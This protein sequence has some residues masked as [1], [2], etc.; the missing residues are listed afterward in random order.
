VRVLLLV[1]ELPEPRV[2]GA[3]PVAHVIG[4]LGQ[5]LRRLRIELVAL[6]HVGPGR[7]EEV[8]VASELELGAGL[9]PEPDRLRAA[10]A[11]PVELLAT[12]EHRAV[13]LV[14][15]IDVR[16]SR[17]NRP[18]E[19]PERRMRLLAKADADQGLDRPARVTRPGIAVVPVA[20]T[21]DPL[22]Q[23][24][25]RRGDDRTRAAADQ[26]L[27]RE[28]AAFDGVAPRAFV[29]VRTEPAAPGGGGP[30]EP[31]LEL[32]ARRAWAWPAV[33]VD[34]AEQCRPAAGD[35]EAAGVAGVPRERVPG[36]R[37]AVL[38]AR[39]APLHG[40]RSR[41]ALD[42]PDE[43]PPGE[44]ASVVQR[45]RVRHAHRPAG[46]AERG[47]ENVRVR[48]VVTLGSKRLVR[49]EDERA[50]GVRVEERG[51][52][53]VGIVTGKAQPVDRAVEGDERDRLSVADRSVI[54]D[55][56]I[57]VDSRRLA[58]GLP[59]HAGHLPV[60]RNGCATDT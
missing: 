36:S 3:P 12:T 23:R 34:E 53:G 35:P 22:R 17:A 37:L 41:Q 15:R 55:R 11:R 7:V 42:P 40:H 10:V 50:A 24:G 30:L 52:R 21:A 16:S 25:G 48:Q 59:P 58:R 43:L 2:G 20:G 32:V 4:D 44:V 14:D 57:A 46:G 19:P 51:E 28:Q 56:R 49:A 60:S 27:E 29:R 26:E 45:Q 39:D 6:V 8:A 38:G 54:L 9:V 1:R 33:G 18:Q 5:Q 31:G 13:E 47:L